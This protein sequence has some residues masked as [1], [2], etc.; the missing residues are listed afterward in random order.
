MMIFLDIP[1]CGQY[2]RTVR[3]S[4]NGHPVAA[5]VIESAATRPIE[6]EQVDGVYLL[7][8]AD[9]SVVEGRME[10][11]PE[12][13]ERKKWDVAPRCA[14]SRFRGRGAHTGR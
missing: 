5:A 13:A 3:T 1:Q 4:G 7:R 2:V 10:T 12:I 14:Q 11:V 9:G 8:M 6:V